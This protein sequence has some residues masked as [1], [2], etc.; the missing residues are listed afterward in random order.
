[1]F[2]TLDGLCA[3]VLAV[4]NLRSDHLLK[5]DRQR[6]HAQDYTYN[7]ATVQ[8]GRPAQLNMRN[9]L[10]TTRPVQRPPPASSSLPLPLPLLVL[11]TSSCL[12]GG[13]EGDTD[14]TLKPL[15]NCCA[16]CCCRFCN[17]C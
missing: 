9:S 17:C 12:P 13:G 11:L 10:S 4:L 7:S 14:C 15:S 2:C 3:A 8:A 16:A 6:K 5:N 1:M